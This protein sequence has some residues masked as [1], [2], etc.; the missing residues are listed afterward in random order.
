MKAADRCD[1]YED[2]EDIE[3]A[4]DCDGCED[5]KDC[6]DCEDSD[7]YEV[8]LVSAVFCL[9]VD[10]VQWALVWAAPVVL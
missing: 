6:E 4:D 1:G 7:G 3:D 9:S 10:K 5:C 2:R 8:C